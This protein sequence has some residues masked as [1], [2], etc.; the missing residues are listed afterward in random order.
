M[1]LNIL[2]QAII[3]ASAVKEGKVEGVNSLVGTA[4]S[5]GSEHFKF[6]FLDTGLSEAILV[7]KADLGELFAG[8]PQ[9]ITGLSFKTNGFTDLSLLD[10]NLGID[11]G[12]EESL[13]VNASEEPVNSD[14]FSTAFDTW[15][16]L[17][18]ISNLSR[19]EVDLSMV[20]NYLTIDCRSAVLYKG[21]VTVKFRDFSEEEL[22]NEFP[23]VEN[24]PQ[25]TGNELIL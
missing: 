24:Q 7:Q 3:V 5:V 17:V 4:T 9:D 21:S 8:I 18:G 19:Q 6:S 22:L 16:R 20:G 2:S 13:A 1:R 23:L 14:M 10:E 15:I 25:E 12:K 11:K